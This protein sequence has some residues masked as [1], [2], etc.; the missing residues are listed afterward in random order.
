M[1]SVDTIPPEDRLFE[2]LT[3]RGTADSR[4]LTSLERNAPSWDSS[5]T[6]QLLDANQQSEPEKITPLTEAAPG[7][8]G[9]SSVGATGATELQ[10]TRDDRTTDLRAARGFA[11]ALLLGAALWTAIII[12]I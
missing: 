4:R 5:R 12:G 2:S 8:E 6:A 11:W 7:T 3:G 9:P 1:A 10:S